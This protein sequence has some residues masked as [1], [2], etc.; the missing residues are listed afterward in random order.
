MGASDMDRFDC[1]ILAE[2]EQDSRQG[3]GTIADKVGLSKTPCWNRVQSLE[4]RRVITG[5]RAT[6]DPHAIG[7][8]LSAFVEV[9]VDFAHHAAFEAAVL[10]HA[11]ILDC[12]TVAGDGDYLLHV[13]TR[14]VETLDG[15]LRSELSRLPGVQ[16]FASTICMKTIKRAAPLMATVKV[17]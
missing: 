4:Q 8:R 9:S 13:I 5:Y 14:D 3:F 1:A 10:D 7:L 12:Y 16:R 17:A 2:L 6:I 11:A 15:L